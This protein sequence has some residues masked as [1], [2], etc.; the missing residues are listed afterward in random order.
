MIYHKC[1]ISDKAELEKKKHKLMLLDENHIDIEKVKYVS[2]KQNLIRLS[3]YS[4]ALM[5]LM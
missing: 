2:N 5:D 4:A 3:I 1:E